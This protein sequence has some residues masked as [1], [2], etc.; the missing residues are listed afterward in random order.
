M[1]QNIPTG[2]QQFFDIN[3]KPLVGGKV[4]NYVVATTI[5][6][7]TYQ[8]SAQTT[9]NANPVILDARGQCSM[10]GSGSYRQVLKD[11]AD[12]LIWDQVIIDLAQTVNDNLIQFQADL[13]SQSDVS[14][15]ANLVG[16]LQAGIGAVGQT[17]L[18]KARNVVTAEDFGCVGDGVTDDT[19]NMQKALNAMGLLRG[20]AVL[21]RKRYLIN[22]ANLTLP[23]NVRMVGTWNPAGQNPFETTVQ[24]HDLSCTIIMN[25]TYSIVLSAGA[26][27][28][29]LS[30]IRKGLTTGEA[31]TSL[32]AGTA[33]Q[34]IGA[35]GQNGVTLQNLQILGFAQAG[36]FSTC[37]RLYIN[38]VS[39]DNIAGFRIGLC[40]DVIRIKNVHFWPFITNGAG[41]VGAANNRSGTAFLFAQH[42]DIAQFEGIFTYGYL[43]GFD[44]VGDL[45]TATFVNCHADNTG[46][47]PG[48]IGFLIE[49]N[50][51]HTVFIG[52]SAYSCTTGFYCT[53]GVTDHIYYTTC[54]AIGNTGYGW[55][56]QQGSVHLLGCEASGSPQGIYVYATGTLAYVT[57]CTIINNSSNGIIAG[58]GAY[59]IERNNFFDTASNGGWSVEVIPSQDPLPLPNRGDFFTV[60]G[61]TSFGN[62]PNGWAGRKITLYFTGTLTVNNGSGVRMGSSF[63]ATA[64]DILELIHTGS[65]WVKV[66]SSAN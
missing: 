31:N 22:S 40:Y 34:I 3:G 21:C 13:A 12:N 46:V 14:K 35:S 54:R 32:F 50:A 25:T 28:N 16:F 37:A 36:Y 5:P 39:G 51:T 20:G 2:K 38:N 29:N 1:S 24:V 17:L 10:Y 23:E 61:T 45:G 62:I 64:D 33:I 42:I 63:A 9:P 47:N 15:G 41:M 48:S 6:K 11:S 59:V 49:G 66:A 7:N 56:I 58:S 26:E 4:F 65:Y 52:C 53:P 60:S 19:A 8:D 30:I 43:R 55:N 44:I 18:T 57:N 27:L